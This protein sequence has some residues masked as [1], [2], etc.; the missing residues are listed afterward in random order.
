MVLK[1]AETCILVLMTDVVTSFPPIVGADPR[2]LILGSMPGEAS[3]R[4]GEYYA[5]P[6]N[7][8]WRIVG[9]A[10][11][12]DADAPYAER[13]AALVANGVAL[14][15]VAAACIRPGS[16]DTSIVG[17]S[18]VPNDIGGLLSS[19]TGIRRICFNGAA[20]QTL[21]RRHVEPILSAVP[22][23]L[24]R[25][26]RIRLPSTSPANASIPF[27]RKRVAWALALRSE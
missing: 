14:W 22:P 3:L 23:V 17:E 10:V 2:V 11:G 15:D 6:R 20:A 8:F 18:V 7:L 21:F 27:D 9:E 1:V 19:H 4:A 16:L 12:F 24:P 26:E 5:H 13:T 25:V